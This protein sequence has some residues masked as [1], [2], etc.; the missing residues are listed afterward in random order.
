[1][2]T[3]KRI[4]CLT[5]V[6]AA[7]LSCVLTACSSGKNGY[8]INV[9]EEELNAYLGA[10]ELPAF[11]VVSDSGEI[12]SEYKVRVKSVIDPDGENTEVEY[13]YIE[14]EKVGV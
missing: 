4:L 10:Y 12:R 5:I 2:K 6:L 3:R 9:P 1:M 11:D 8:R 7:M 13:G 14:A